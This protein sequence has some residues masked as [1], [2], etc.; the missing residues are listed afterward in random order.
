MKQRIWKV[1][2]LLGMAV[3]FNSG[4][5][6]VADAWMTGWTSAAAQNQ[7]MLVHGD[8]PSLGQQRLTSQSGVY[9]DLAAFIRTRGTPDFVA[10]SSTRD[11]HF[12]ILYYLV[13]KR[14]YACRAKAPSTRQMEITG[15]Y[16]IT[17]QVYQLLRGFKQQAAGRSAAKRKASD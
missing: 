6:P 5:Q 11:R 7:I 13:S 9:P 10:E 17:H 1:W 15:P 3:V 2:G 12:L 16:P 14:A 4:C 8:P